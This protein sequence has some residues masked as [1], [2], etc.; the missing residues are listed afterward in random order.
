MLGRLLAEEREAHGH[1]AC[2]Q[3]VTMET[4]AGESRRQSLALNGPQRLP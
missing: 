3:G 2:P 1:E 4:M